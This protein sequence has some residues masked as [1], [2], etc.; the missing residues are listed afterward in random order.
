MSLPSTMKAVVLKEMYRVAVD[1]VPV[2]KIK[3]D[4]DVLI[5]VH[6]A[7]LCGEL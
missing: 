1:D 3:E 2:P 5:K 7:G 6:L 4:G